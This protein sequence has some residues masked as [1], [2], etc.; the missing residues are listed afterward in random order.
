MLVCC[1]LIP[2]L[3]SGYVFDILGSIVETDNA[4]RSGLKVF[5]CPEEEAFCMTGDCTWC[6]WAVTTGSP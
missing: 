2:F 5:Q 4:S 3:N 1:P 6:W